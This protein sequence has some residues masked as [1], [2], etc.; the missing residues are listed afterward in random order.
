MTMKPVPRSAPA[1][2]DKCGRKNAT[3]GACSWKRKKPRKAAA[4][5][6]RVESQTIE[7][8][9]IMFVFIDLP[10][11]TVLLLVE[12]FLLALGQVTVVS[13]HVGLL[14]VLDMLFAVLQT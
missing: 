11:G 12:L 14:L 13:G 4:L 3:P 5:V 2:I 8:L 6:L 9:A 7:L 1:I 10:A